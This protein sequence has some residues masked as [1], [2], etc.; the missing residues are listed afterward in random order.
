[1]TLE[2]MGVVLQV[3]H[4]TAEDHSADSRAE[5]QEWAVSDILC[6]GRFKKSIAQVKTFAEAA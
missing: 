5:Q 4:P 3:G 6:V 2:I 1:M